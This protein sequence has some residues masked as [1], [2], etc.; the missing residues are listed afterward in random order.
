MALAAGALAMVAQ[1]WAQSQL[2]ASRAALL[3][4]ME[5]VFAAGFAAAFG[6]ESL[7]P[8][9]VVGGVLVLAAM[10][11]AERSG[12]AGAAIHAHLD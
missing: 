9:V 12:R 1:T 2:D 4:T 3:M 8:R 10:M 5:P 7:G 6:N 11:L